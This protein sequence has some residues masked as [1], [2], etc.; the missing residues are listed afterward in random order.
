[1][2]DKFTEISKLLDL[3]PENAI[4]DKIA[5]RQKEVIIKAYCYLSRSKE[6]KIVY[7]ADEVGLGK[8]YIALGILT[9]FRHY[10]RSS[11]HKEIIIVPKKNLQF[12]WQKELAGFVQDNYKGSSPLVKKLTENENPVKEKLELLKMDEDYAIFRMSSFSNI[13]STK[14]LSELKSI[15]KDELSQEILNIAKEKGYFQSLNTPKPNARKLIHLLA[16]LYNIQMPRLCCLVVDEAHIYKYGPDNEHQQSSF[17]NEV[18]ARFL[19]A[20]RDKELFKDFPQLKGKVKFPLAQK[21]ICLSATPKDRQIEEIRNQFNCF[22]NNHILTDAISAEKIKEALPKFLIRGNMEYEIGGELVSRNV[23]RHEHRQGNINKSENPEPLM[24]RDDFE[25]IF[26]QLLQYQSLKHLNLNNGAAFEIGMLTGFESYKYDTKKWKRQGTDE[27]D[28]KEFD[29]VSN[30]SKKVS[31][32]YDIIKEIIDSYTLKFNSELPPHPKQSRFE[33]EIVIQMER[34]EKSLTFVRR[35]AS[36]HELEN[37][38]LHLYEKEVVIGRLLNF[39]KEYLKFHSEAVENLINRWSKKDQLQKLGELFQLLSNKSAI[40]KIM[41]NLD[42]TNQSEILTYLNDA[43]L[44]DE[45]FKME[46]ER[47]AS[48]NYKSIA[49]SLLQ[50]AINALN[51]Q[52]AFGR[53]DE[54]LELQ[55]ADEQE[56]DEDKFFF[57]NYF[58]RGRGG[59]RFRNKIYRELWF[60]IDLTFLNNHFRFLQ[61]DEEDGFFTLEKVESLEKTKKHKDYEQY[62]TKLKKWV[63]ENSTLEEISRKGSLIP[64]MEN[65]RTENTFLTKLLTTYCQ[66]EFG[67]WLIKRIKNKDTTNLISEIDRLNTIIRS[68]MRN[69]SGL[70]PSFVADA[71]EGNFEDNLLALIVKEDAPFHYLLK[72]ISTIITD[73]DLIMALNFKN[74]TDKE[75][76]TILKSLSPVI[77]ISG[78]VKRD[79]SIVAAQFRMPGYPYVLITTDILREGEDL[80]TYCQNVY[81][82]GIAWNPSDMEQRTGRIDRIN[83][84][85]YRK[86]KQNKTLDFDNK[87][88]IFYPYL[89][90]SIEVNQVYQLLLNINTFIKTFNDITSHEE[91]KPTV[92]LGEEITSKQIPEAIKHRIE[93][94]FDIENFDKEDY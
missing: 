56:M 72:E 57:N 73:Y 49:N 75:I 65:R 83:S 70:L 36:S 88:Q 76:S 25:G 46:A 71:A 9:L 22:S 45:N 32:D 64:Q 27:K 86:L 21:I 50:A 40:M 67:Q 20:Y 63:Q 59:S 14:K 28:N 37:R 15:F 23:S 35:I 42:I 62:Q 6:N 26:W 30:K 31:L 39:R 55:E 80:H 43:F 90:Q 51:N 53:E 19:G 92:N 17:R 24:I 16:Y 93:P 66:K 10:S 58:K 52:S 33:K 5:N 38:I 61:F 78:M 12:K 41:A 68:I 13:L 48:K 79:R 11:V 4:D 74:K 2:P 3:N 18:T 91:Y 1:M 81:H 54:E 29:L 47:F 7:I 82:Y 77:G 44:S 94:L 84:L 34:Q 85:S 8:T 69:G 87:I 60:E 89:S